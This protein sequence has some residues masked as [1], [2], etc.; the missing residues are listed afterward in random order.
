MTPSTNE[1]PTILVVDDSPTNLSLL[2]NLLKEKYRVK[3]ANN[4]IKALELAA[5]TPPD[6]V[7]LDIMMPDLDGYE[8]CRRLKAANLTR[9]VPVI[10]LTAKTEIE[11]EEL[12]FSVGAVDFIH[13]P[14]SPPIVLARVMTHLEIKSLHDSLRVQNHFIKK[15]FSRYM[16][17]EVV[18]KLLESPDGLNL[19][20]ESL[21]VTIV[22]TDLRGFSTISE[23]VPPESVVRMLNSYLSRMTDIIFRYSGT[24]IEIIGDAIMI[25]FGAPVS[26]P[27]DADRAIICALEMQLAMDTVNELNRK[28]N[29]PELEMGIGINTG[30]VVAGN[31]GSDMRV[32]YAV[33]GSNV[34]LAGRVESFSVGGQ[35]LITESTLNAASLN[36][37]VNDEHTISFKGLE[38]P[39]KIYD[40]TGIGGM[41]DFT[42]DRGTY[43]ITLP[44]PEIEYESL[45]KEIPVSLEILDG[46]YATGEKVAGR[47]LKWAK[48]SAIFTAEVELTE[49]INLKVYFK[50]QSTSR[51]CIIYAKVVNAKPEILNCYEMRF[52]SLK[53]VLPELEIGNFV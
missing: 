37:E 48:K 40:V 16:S 52:T 6:L 27:D 10:F 34:N 12:G 28:F 8:V 31:I 47:I 33:V 51:D 9:L 17:D 29:Q 42:G 35:V 2:S 19:G 43:E 36:I 26:R 22:M 18:E 21:T 38:K 39:V 50:D 46:K 41:F 25:I 32:K 7:L 23:K 1:R 13:K 5:V 11:D 30:K 45:E 14:F 44:H 15:T 24:I 4:G 53:N 49:L 20:G 3:V